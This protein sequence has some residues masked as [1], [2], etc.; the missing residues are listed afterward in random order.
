MFGM[1]WGSV[2]VGVVAVFL[3]ILLLLPDHTGNRG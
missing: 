3:V 1:D 2:F